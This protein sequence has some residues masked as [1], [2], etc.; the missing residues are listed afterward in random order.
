MRHE[1]HY[2]RPFEP[3]DLQAV[4]SLLDS[5]LPFDDVSP[6]WVREKTVADPDHDPQLVLCTSDGHRLVGFVHGIVRPGKPHARGCIKW[7]ATDLG[8]RRSGIATD[9]FDKIERAM[10][11]DGARTVS[12][13]SLPPNYTL[14]GL[15]PR[16]TEAYVFL[17]RRGYERTQ[18]TF[19][20]TCDLLADDWDTS[21][22]ARHFE[23]GGL[24]IRRAMRSDMPLV[25]DF[26]T[27]NFEGW[28]P[29][30]A[31][32]FVNT[33]ISV[34]I[35]VD[36][37]DGGV[38]AFSAYDACN[39]GMGW[40]GPMGTTKNRRGHGIGT[41]LLRRCLGDL[42]GQGH[43]T[44]TIPW[45]GPASFYHRECGATISRVFWQME[46][47]LGDVREQGPD[48]ANRRAREPANRRITLPADRR[49]GV[50][51]ER[52]TEESANDPTG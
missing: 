38:V 45:V 50:P 34:H 15:D 47:K 37:T 42:R 46:K 43:S 49:S 16:Y 23:H 11:R 18:E 24:T 33:P 10:Y 8:E 27:E 48:P 17:E 41:T 26:M 28:V 9:M 12:I 51:A 52:R 29:E 1:S 3:G 36:K 4:A 40:F 6:E 31:A 22:A 30:V 20:M 21:T 7:F 5:N 14:P 2:T 44:A 32:C 35:A 13:A 25:R 19:N 39:I